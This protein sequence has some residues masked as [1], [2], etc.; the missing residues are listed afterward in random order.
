MLRCWP[1]C[2]WG[3]RRRL[4]IAS[5]DNWA[6][7][8][9]THRALLLP[10]L[11]IPEPQIVADKH[12]DRPFRSEFSWEEHQHGSAA[13][14]SQLMQDAAGVTVPFKAPSKRPNDLMM[15]C[16]HGVPSTHDP[17]VKC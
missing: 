10:A 5:G 4:C 3:T 15:V 13:S 7:R 11:P 16:E 12:S 2:R 1:L 17:S 8:R 14:R 6:D 9:A